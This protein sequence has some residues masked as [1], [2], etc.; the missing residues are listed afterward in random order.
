MQSEATASSTGNPNEMLGTNT[1]SMTSRWSQSASLRLIIS[2]SRSRCR[3][4]AASNDGETNVILEFDLVQT[5][6]LSVVHTI[7]I[8][9]IPNQIECLLARFQSFTHGSDYV[10]NLLSRYLHRQHHIFRGC[11]NRC[12]S[13][14]HLF[15]ICPHLKNMECCC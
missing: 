4:S 11:L 2:I 3:K 8:S 12:M 7:G 13:Q 10:N 15:L 9:E 6:C 5:I 1:P 14:R